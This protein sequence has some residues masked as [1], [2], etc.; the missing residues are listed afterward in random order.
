MVSEDVEIG[1]KVSYENNNY[2]GFTFDDSKT[3]NKDATVPDNNN[4]VVKLYYTR[5]NDLSYTVYYKEQGTETKLAE[6]KVVN[7]KTFEEVITASIK[8][9]DNATEK[10][11]TIDG[12]E[13]VEVKP[14]ELSIG[15]GEN[16][17]TFYY[18]KLCQYKIE[19]Y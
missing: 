1:T 15:T 5:R 16:V 6:A 18:V 2:E 12:Y 9:E 19:Y 10:P 13:C 11:K 7:N 8:A 3:E 4:L 14:G 17:I